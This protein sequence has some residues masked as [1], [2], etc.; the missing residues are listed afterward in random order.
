MP[1]AEVDPSRPWVAASVSGRTVRLDPNPDPPA[2]GIV[3]FMIETDG[4][5]P[6][7]VDFASPAMPMHGVMRVPVESAGA[8]WSVSI[9]IPMAGDWAL[10]VNFDD[11]DDAAEFR[12]SV[13]GDGHEHVGAGAP[14]THHH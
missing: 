12:F 5:T 8:A 1:A 4:A 7:S 2:V 9:D 11:G 6:R 14:A 3:H 10:Y 13:A